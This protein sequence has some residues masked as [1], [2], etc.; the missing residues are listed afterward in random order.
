VTSVTKVMNTYCAAA[1]FQHFYRCFTIRSRIYWI[2]IIS[3]RPY[4]VIPWSFTQGLTSFNTVCN[5]ISDTNGKKN[6]LIAHTI[7]SITDH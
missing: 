6:S 1:K 5:F 7:I 3:F 4:T 2:N